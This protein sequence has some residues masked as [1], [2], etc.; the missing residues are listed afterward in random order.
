MAEKED[1]SIFQDFINSLEHSNSNESTQPSPVTPDSPFAHITSLASETKAIPRY[2]LQI[3]TASFETILEPNYAD[4]SVTLTYPSR[5]MQF[6]PEEL[7]SNTMQVITAADLR[8]GYALE[9]RLHDGQREASF[10]LRDAWQMKAYEKTLENPLKTVAYIV[11]QLPLEGFP[12]GSAFS[13]QLLAFGINCLD[14]DFTE[15][16]QMN[17]DKARYMGPE[18]ATELITRNRGYI[19]GDLSSDTEVFRDSLRALCAKHPIE[20]TL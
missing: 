19:N 3:G 4:S 14:G 17:Y 15:F 1:L 16:M 11:N 2:A 12:Q 8:Q 7:F 9:A 20:K 18:F 5:L 10:D 6:E 13:K